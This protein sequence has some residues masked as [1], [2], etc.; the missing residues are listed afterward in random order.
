MASYSTGFVDTNL[1]TGGGTTTFDGGVVAANYVLGFVATST[2]KGDGL[3]SVSG[4]LYRSGYSVIELPRFG[5]L[6]SPLSRSHE[7]AEPILLS[8]AHNSLIFIPGGD[9]KTGLA[10]LTLSAVSLSK[11]GGAFSSIS[12]PTITDRGTGNYTVAL[13]TSDTNTNGILKMRGTATPTAGAPFLFEVVLGFVT[14]TDPATALATAAGTAGFATATALS[15]AQTEITAIHTL[16][17][18]GATAAALSTA[19]STLSSLLTSVPA[20]VWAVV[21]EGTET[22][23]I[24]M[25][26]MTAVIYRRADGLTAGGQPIFYGADNTTARVTDTIVAGARTTVLNPA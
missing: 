8:S 22:A 9:G 7:M 25:R 16:A 18:A 24:M 5:A 15:T 26:L 10:G 17:S 4:G 23:Q 13:T 20:D 2:F 6:Q 21:L 19:V 3:T 12:T 14:A 11:A 1:F